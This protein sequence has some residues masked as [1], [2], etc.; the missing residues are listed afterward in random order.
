MN[1][2][3]RGEKPEV[4]NPIVAYASQT[5]K[6]LLFFNKKGMTSHKS[7]ESVLALYEATDLNK[8]P[9]HEIAFR[10]HGQEHSL[11]ASSD[12]ERDGWYMAIEKA[13][14]LGKANKEDVRESEGY[15]SEMEKLSEFFYPQSSMLLY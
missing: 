14:E 15:K 6:G 2:F 1:S 13:M 3:M 11:K 10:L 7:P 12:A 9:T 8:Q 4:A 5:G